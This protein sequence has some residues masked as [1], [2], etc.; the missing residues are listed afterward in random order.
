MSMKV[1]LKVYIYLFVEGYY[2]AWVFN[3]STLYYRYVGE[4]M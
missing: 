3:E 2:T 4:K 1:L